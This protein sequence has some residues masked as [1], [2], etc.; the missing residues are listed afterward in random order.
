MISLEDYN[1]K[2]ASYKKTMVFHFGA[3]AGFYSEYNNMLK[4]MAFCLVHKIRFKLYSKDSMFCPVNGWTDYFEPFVEE[5]DDEIHHLY[6]KRF[7]ENPTRTAF[8]GVFIKRKI[9]R[10]LGDKSW[11]VSFSFYDTFVRNRRLKW[12]YGFDFFTF[13]LW[14][15]FFHINPAKKVRVRSVFSGTY[16][17]LI[18]DLDEMIWRF[19]IETKSKVDKFLLN[20]LLSEAFVGMHIRGGD[21]SIEAELISWDKYTERAKLDRPE[22]RNWFIFTD[23]Y[24]IVESIQNA[25]PQ[26]KVYSLCDISERGYYYGEFVADKEKI[27]DKMIRMFASVEMCKK[28]DYFIGTASSNPYY[29]ISLFKGGKNCVS[30]D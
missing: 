9:Y 28:A 20:T 16:L 8:F 27:V 17:E 2:N 3:F 26:H 1:K 13:D 19:N 6:N 5:V 29:V 21:K 22:C 25:Y 24:S 12:K 15:D 7:P 14:N 23:D 4:A 10:M 18:K 11:K 30:L